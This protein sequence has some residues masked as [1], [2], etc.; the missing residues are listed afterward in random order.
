VKDHAPG[1]AVAPE[2]DAAAKSTGR[3]ALGG[4][5]TT[6]VL[7]LQ[8]TAGNAAVN[9]ILARRERGGGAT[10]TQAQDWTTADR[11]GNTARWQSA[12]EANLLAG[13]SS[14]YTSPAERSAFY[15]WFYIATT[16]HPDPARRSE[17]RWPLA[18][19]VVAAGVWG[20]VD[21]PNSEGLA[22]TAGVTSE[23]VQAILRRGNQVIMDDVFPKLRDLWLNPRRGQAAL[24]WDAETLAEEQNLVQPLYDGASAEANTIL[25][26]MADGTWTSAQVGAS[27]FAAG[28]VEPGPNIRGGR[29]PFF[30]GRMRDMATRWRYG[31]LIANTFSTLSPTGTAPTSPP[32]VDAGYSGGGMFSSL[33]WRRHLHEWE[34]ATDNMITPQEESA[35][36]VAAMRAFTPREQHHFLGNWDFYMTRCRAGGF[37]G[38]QAL[39]GMTPWEA[40]L[41]VQI[42]FIDALGI[43]WPSVEYG[44]GNLDLRPMVRNASQAGRDGVRGAFFQ[45]I[46]ERVC[47]DSTIVT[48]ANDLALP[49]AERDRWIESE[50]AIF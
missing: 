5:S 34:A 11:E 49:A 4:F 17:C 35:A 18:A 43:T 20:M 1:P 12:N 27:V 25:Q 47:D 28:T 42:R 6:S 21:M 10:I 19:S 3:Q 48:A 13:R 44:S 50:R 40:N 33:D 8:R 38:V 16:N 23:E 46:F 32:S 45:S 36:A 41:P 26:N 22:K 15:R 39:R 9:R 31:N 24:D 14:E 29:V 7:S 37:H 30:S 2:Q